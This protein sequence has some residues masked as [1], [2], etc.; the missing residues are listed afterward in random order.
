L[1]GEIVLTDRAAELLQH[2]A[3]LA[4]GVQGFTRSAA[5]DLP[6]EHGLDPVPLVLVGN[7]RQAHDLPLLL[8]QYMAGEV[9]LVQ[10][11]HDQHDRPLPLVV[12]PAVEGV[13]VPFVGRLALRLRQRLLGHQRVVDDDDVGAAQSAMQREACESGAWRMPRPC[14]V[15]RRRRR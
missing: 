4:L 6:P 1:A 9:V 14:A 8:G 7:R 2:L 3:R 12:E 10:P 15:S 5:K 11:V 13:V